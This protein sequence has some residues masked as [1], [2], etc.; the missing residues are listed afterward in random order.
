MRLIPV[1]P[2]SIPPAPNKPGRSRVKEALGL[3]EGG[4]AVTDGETYPGRHE[5]RAACNGLLTSLY[6]YKREGRAEVGFTSRVYE[7]GKGEW[8]WAIVPAAR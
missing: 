2:K 4:S 3:I 6:R 5:A 8:R 1:D 7:D